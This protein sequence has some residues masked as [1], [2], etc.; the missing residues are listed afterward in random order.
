MTITDKQAYQI[1]G[2]T[3]LT[4]TVMAAAGDRVIASVVTRDTFTAP[5]G[6]TTLYESGIYDSTQG[7]GQRAFALCKVID[8][9][10][11]VSF[12]ATQASSQ[13]LYLN[14]ISISGCGNVEAYTS[15]CKTESGASISA[16]NK[17]SGEAIIWALSSAYWTLTSPYAQWATSPSDLALLDLGTSVQSRLGN[18]IDLGSGTA[19]GRTFT[20][21][22]GNSNPIN[23][24]AIRLY[25]KSYKSSGNAIFTVAGITATV[26]ASSISW[27]ESK[28]TGTTLTVSVS[29]DGTNFSAVTNSGALLAADTI[30]DNATIYIK[31]E[32]STTDTAT[33]PTLSDLYISLQS[34]D[35]T[36]SIVLEM[37]PLQRFESAAG[38]ITVAYDGNGTLQ[39][40]GGPV[41]AF[42][43]S[44]APTDLIPK[45]DQNDQEHINIA[46]ISAASNLMRIYYTNTYENEHI[47][48]ASITAVGTLTNIKDL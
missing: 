34:V 16:G 27:S 33:T 30:L 28:P 32:M 4:G 47:N 41:A 45:P 29:T 18:F 21:P 39:G 5:V 23:V 38:N 2:G 11:T 10:G 3:T 24:I 12:T 40:A 1:T 44:F 14:L 37:E 8:T 9:A 20:Q 48:I 13:R 19:T 26:T 25:D 31:V 46:S 36:Y 6:W 43:Q 15:L 7:N 22:T 17:N 42:E 35:D